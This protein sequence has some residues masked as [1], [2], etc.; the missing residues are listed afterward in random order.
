[1]ATVIYLK[2]VEVRYAWF[3]VSI[4]RLKYLNVVVSYTLKIILH[5]HDITVNKANENA[6][7]N[8]FAGRIKYV[9]LKWFQPK[10]V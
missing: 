3:N 6:E 4:R 7:K 1:M 9:T 2:R 8:N 5:G 10:Q